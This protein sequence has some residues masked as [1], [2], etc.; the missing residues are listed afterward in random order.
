MG[1]ARLTLRLRGWSG[2]WGSFGMLGGL[3]SCQPV[4][5]WE[6]ASRLTIC[7]VRGF[8][9][10]LRRWRRVFWWFLLCGWDCECRANR[11]LRGVSGEWSRWQE[12]REWERKPFVE[13]AKK[14]G[15]E[16]G[17][18][19]RPISNHERASAFRMWG[20]W[21]SIPRRGCG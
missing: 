10:N 7:A 17:R 18:L 11:W 14:V 16:L 13:R 2:R 9:F 21:T 4:L 8:G 12:R 6:H 5:W 1:R 20:R 15:C 3:Q 19:W